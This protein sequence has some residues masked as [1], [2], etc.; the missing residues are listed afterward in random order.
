MLNLQEYNVAPVICIHKYHMDVVLV[1]G[2]FDPHGQA[3]SKAAKSLG[4]KLIVGLNSDEWLT[5]KKGK[6]FMP[7]H[8]RIEIIRGL[9]VVD[10][11]ISF[12][13]SDDTA[14]GAIYK[15][16]AT[17]SGSQIIFAN[18]GDRTDENIPEMQIYGDTYYVRFVF[19]VGGEDKKNSSSWI[20]KDWKAPKVEREWGHY[21]ELYL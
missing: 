3:Y 18:G 16:L 14:C 20:L 8:E 10:E 21:R 7:F 17:K 9:S 1:T 15:T 11:V 6:P 4:D 19:G 13:D 12:D 2:G 5:R